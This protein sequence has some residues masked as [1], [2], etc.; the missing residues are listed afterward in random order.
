MNRVEWTCPSCSRK[1]SV[2]ST[3]G[4]TTC[5]DCQGKEWT[6][7]RVIVSSESIRAALAKPVPA[8]K[9]VLSK[10]KKP[11]NRT[12]TAIA[13]I[14][15]ACVVVPITVSEFRETSKLSAVNRES[16]KTTDGVLRVT[17]EINEKTDK[18]ESAARTKRD[19]E[20][21]AMQRSFE[22]ERARKI[23][24][25]TL[26]SFVATLG[27]D[28]EIQSTNVVA[29]PFPGGPD[30]YLTQLSSTTFDGT[31]HV[32]VFGMTRDSVYSIQVNAMSS[33]SDG[34]RKIAVSRFMKVASLTYSGCAPEP[35]MKWV[36]DNFNRIGSKIVI[37]RAKFSIYG[38]DT[39]RILQI[40]ND[41]F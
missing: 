21:L 32:E 41:D 6:A 24:G 39:S 23:P 11:M 8:S 27:R 29:N 38:N 17:D 35:A 33:T 4:L 12:A 22:K 10:T 9:L 14:A 36:S 3:E 13:I 20:D 2:P 5:P 40:E 28:F 31:C 26:D 25:L 15:I 1:F 7:D 37:G 30:T 34:L 18:A 16:E 19:V